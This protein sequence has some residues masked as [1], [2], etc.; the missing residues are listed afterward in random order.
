MKT[1]KQQVN[2]IYVLG[3][4]ISTMLILFGTITSISLWIDGYQLRSVMGSLL[5]VIIGGMLLVFLLLILETKKSY[6]MNQLI[7][8]GYSIGIGLILFSI[9]VGVNSGTTMNSWEIALSSGMLFFTSG[10]GILVALLVGFGW[11]KNKEISGE[12]E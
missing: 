4:A 2:V 3:I 1:N 5:F 6:G 7:A 11:K 10:V 9:F 8:A 12:S